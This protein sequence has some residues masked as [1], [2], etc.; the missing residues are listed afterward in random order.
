[1]CPFAL[2]REVSFA[3]DLVCDLASLPSPLALYQHG[4]P[5]LVSPDSALW[6]SE[7]RMVLTALKRARECVRQLEGGHPALFSVDGTPLKWPCAT[8]N[9]LFVREYYAPMYEA[10][11]Q[12]CTR[13]K[14]QGHHKH[15]VT[16]QPGIGKPVFR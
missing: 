11:L 13:R 4:K 16:G 2:L 9:V 14:P 15:I 3:P 6:T 10:V 8:N 5:E 7:T 1:M 12:R